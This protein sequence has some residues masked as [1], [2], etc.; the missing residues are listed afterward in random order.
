MLLAIAIKAFADLRRRPLQTVVLFLVTA[1]AAFLL[2]LS[3]N[4]RRGLDNPWGRV[5]EQSNGA[6][7]WTLAYSTFREDWPT[8]KLSALSTLPGVTAS[9]GPRAVS[10]P[11]VSREYGVPFIV[12]ELPVQEAEVA[13]PVITSGGWLGS[14][15]DI[16]LDVSLAY[17][18]GV[19]PGDTVSLRTTGGA[20]ALRVAGLVQDPGSRSRAGYVAKGF[21]AANY[22]GTRFNY[23]LGVRLSDPTQTA[24]Y[25]SAAR[26]LFPSGYPVDFYD[27]K[28]FERQDAA[29]VKIRAIFISVFSVFALLVAAFIIVNATSARVLTQYRDFGILKAIGFTP[30]QVAA[31]FLVAQAG[32]ALLAG[33]TGALA[34][35]AYSP[36]M[37]DDAARALRTV[38][39]GPWSLAVIAGAAS[40]VTVLAGVATLVPALKA[41]RLPAVQAIVSR[42]GPAGSGTSAVARAASALHLPA[43]VV[44]GVKDTLG[45]R[46]RAV[47]SVAVLS[48]AAATLTFRAVADTSMDQYALTPSLIGEEPYPAYVFREAP[49]ALTQQ[50][51]EALLRTAPG[52]ASFYTRASYDGVVGGV[53]SEVRAVS[54]AYQDFDWS[55]TSGRLFSGPGEA[56]VGS[57]FVAQSGARVGDALEATVGGATFKV[58]VTGINRSQ[59]DNTPPI[60]L[61]ADTLAAAGVVPTAVRMTGVLPASGVSASRLAADLTLAAAGRLTV[62]DLTAEIRRD[63]DE[64]RPVLYSLSLMLMVIAVAGTLAALL[65]TT[66]ERRREFA[67]LK[68]VGMTPVQVIVGV[69]SGAVLLAAA[70]LLVGVPLGFVLTTQLVKF[71]GDAAGIGAVPWAFPSA[72]SMSL[73]VPIMA[74]VAILGALLPAARASRLRVTEALRAE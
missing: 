50:E 46:T 17:E 61:H 10:P 23:M 72:A 66:E 49:D 11:E 52:V 12:V 47:F 60:T 65:L 63:M 14:A 21:L 20:V 29:D 73:L 70:G 4:L 7:V 16:L 27:W 8:D 3:L 45:N 28:W 41:G 6:H 33:A 30:A 18:M 42:Y 22:P 5:F 71:I 15:S 74:A 1:A 31:V 9:T 67:V 38:P 51:T 26:E 56:V 64:F 68:A 69:S 19:R 24:A 62:G 44:I 37:L 2:T 54:G 32:L 34:G 59:S 57:V 40:A 39:P 43:V 25:I 13:A 55:L 36:V 48:L 53:R 35:A 58:T